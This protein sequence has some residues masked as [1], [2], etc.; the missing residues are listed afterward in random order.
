[1][2]SALSSAG[3][4]VNQGEDVEVVER[5]DQGKKGEEEGEDRH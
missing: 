3:V 1:M 5:F 4:D 2:F